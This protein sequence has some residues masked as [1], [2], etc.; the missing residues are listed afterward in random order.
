MLADVDLFIC[1]QKKAFK[2]AKS[3]LGK[4]EQEYLIHELKNVKDS[5]VK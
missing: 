5:L 2:R 3:K 1:H 4:K